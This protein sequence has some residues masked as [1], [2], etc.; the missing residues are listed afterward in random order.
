MSYATRGG[1]PASSINQLQDS[2]QYYG[3]KERRLLKSQMPPGKAR[4]KGKA[5]GP[6]QTRGPD[7]RTKPVANDLLKQLLA[8]PGGIK[9]MSDAAQYG[10]LVEMRQKQAMIDRSEGAMREMQRVTQSMTAAQAAGVRAGQ[11]PA[12]VSETVRRAVENAQARQRRDLETAGAQVQG[13]LPGQDETGRFMPGGSR[14]L[15]ADPITADVPPITGRDLDRARM[16]GQ[17]GG[18]AVGRA[19]ERR[20]AK[21]RGKGL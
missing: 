20:A 10:K 8:E 5:T 6:S 15:G 2:G 4:G 21:G 18:I 1:A 3:D 12:G 9:Q 17:Q 16:A 19:I 7:Y 11:R 14:F 13:R